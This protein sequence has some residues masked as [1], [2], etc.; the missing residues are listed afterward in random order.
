MLWPWGYG[1]SRPSDTQGLIFP[2]QSMWIT[3]EAT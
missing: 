3:P 2:A 1:A